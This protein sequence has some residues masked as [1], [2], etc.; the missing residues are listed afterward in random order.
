[1]II[2]GA[3]GHGKVIAD[4]LKKNEVSEIVFWDDDINAKV[5]GYKVDKPLSINKEG[6]VIIAVGNNLVRKKIVDTNNFS[7]ATAIHPNAII[8]EN[9]S[10]QEGTVVMAGAIVNPSSNIGKHCILNTSC[11]I[12]HDCQIEDFVHVSPNATLTGDVQV[13]EGAHIGAGAVVIQGIRIG[14]W[15]TIGV[16]AVVIRDVPDYAVVVG[17]PAKIIKYNDLIN[18]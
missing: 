7:C 1:M 18:E 11:S 14:K 9:V 16:G 8:A 5:N 6:K 2:Y 13:G 17:N 12:D 3:S 10:I 4:I 15:A